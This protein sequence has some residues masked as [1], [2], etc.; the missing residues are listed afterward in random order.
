MSHPLFC[1]PIYLPFKREAK[2]SRK[3]FSANYGIE[4]SGFFAENR[5][6]EVESGFNY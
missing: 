4:N 3:W 2:K 5:E 6:K 1:L